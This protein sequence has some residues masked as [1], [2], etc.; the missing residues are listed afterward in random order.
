MTKIK[1]YTLIVL[2]IKI[3][4]KRLEDILNNI[5]EEAK[6]NVVKIL[7]KKIAY[8]YIYMLSFMSMSELMK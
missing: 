4:N 8:K 6:R 2:K 3:Q 5:L 1:K 7:G